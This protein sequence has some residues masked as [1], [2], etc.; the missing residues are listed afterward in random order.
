MVILLIFDGFLYTCSISW[1]VVNWWTNVARFN[2]DCVLQSRVRSCPSSRPT[3]PFA[4][5][6][7]CRAVTANASTRNS[8]VM[9]SP[10]ARTS[11]TRTP[12]VSVLQRTAFAYYTNV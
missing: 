1:T 4:R 9:A 6:E 3:N 11:P 12:A 8:S 5:R 2:G 10:T 7:N